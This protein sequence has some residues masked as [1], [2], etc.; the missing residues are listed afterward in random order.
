MPHKCT[1][2]FYLSRHLTTILSKSGLVP[3]EPTLGHKNDDVATKKG[4]SLVGTKVLNIFF[5]MLKD[6]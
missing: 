1:S 2:T 5:V 6:P 4:I 3:I